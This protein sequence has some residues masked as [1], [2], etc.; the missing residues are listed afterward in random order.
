MD[1][2]ARLGRRRQV[3][4]ARHDARVS[5]VVK[6]C[7]AMNGREST[8]SES[9]RSP[10]ESIESSDEIGVFHA[11]GIPW[12]GDSC[13][14]VESMGERTSSHVALNASSLIPLAAPDQ[15]R[16]PRQADQWRS[17]RP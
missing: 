9:W 4:H 14:R 10:V 16:D 12:P 6:R 8:N 7:L 15:A 13:V 1:P 2:L 3:A 5:I 11:R 17:V